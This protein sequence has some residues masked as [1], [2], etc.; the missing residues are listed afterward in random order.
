[1]YIWTF[2]IVIASGFNM[3][4]GNIGVPCTSEGIFNIKTFTVTPYPPSGC[5]LQTID[6]VGTYT[7]DACTKNI[8]VTEIWNQQKAYNQ[9]IGQTGC[10]KSGDTRDYYFYVSPFQCLKGNYIIQIYLQNTTQDL[11]SCW[12]YEYTL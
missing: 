9:T 10:S 12:R 7:E 3:L 2:L 4:G 11:L 5:A 1:M 8:L 6:M